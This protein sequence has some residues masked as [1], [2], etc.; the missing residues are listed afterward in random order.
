[1]PD[2]STLVSQVE[3]FSQVDIGDGLTMLWEPFVSDLFRCNI[4]HVRG[5]DRDVLIDT[6]MG[7]ASLSTATELFDASILAV[8]THAHMDHSG[9]LHEFDQRAVHEAEVQ[10]VAEATEHFPLVAEQYSEQTLT[11]LAEMGFDLSDG[12]LTAIPRDG[13]DPASHHLEA[14]E[15][16][17]VLQEGDV[18]DLGDR[19]FEVLHLPGHSPG[20]IGLYDRANRVLFGGDAVYDGTLLDE[21]PGS[22]IETY[23]A[24]MERLRGLDVAVAHGGHGPSMDRVRYVEVIEGYLQSRAA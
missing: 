16:T 23:V 17:V 24:T 4:W 9:S 13:F 19:A 10:A 15:A 6:G 7:V 3:W 18:I 12:V 8:A 1:M 14:T 11:A 2:H 20:S 21:L 5:R 22:D